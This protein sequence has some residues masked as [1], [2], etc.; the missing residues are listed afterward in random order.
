MKRGLAFHIFFVLYTVGAVIILILGLLPQFLPASQLSATSIHQAPEH[1]DDPVWLFASGIAEAARHDR[2]IGD[3]LIDY[4]FSAI[5]IV[6]GVYL[7]WR[8]PDDRVT[9]LLGVGMIG[10]A[11]AY[12]FHAHT[13]LIILAFLGY[14][15]P[16]PL[17]MASHV[18]HFGLHAISGAVYLHALL[19][20]PDGQLVPRRAVWLLGVIYFLMAQE[21]ILSPITGNGILSGTF[22]SFF[23]PSLFGIPSIAVLVEA[24]PQVNKLDV[25]IE[26]VFYVVLFGLLIPIVGAATQVYRY[27]KVAT[28]EERQQTKIV[29][30]SLA[31]AF[32]VAVLYAVLLVASAILRQ[33]GAISVE[34]GQ[35]IE[36]LIF[37]VFPLIFVIIPISMG[38]AIQRYGLWDI[39]FIVNRTLVYSG[40]TVLLAGIFVGVFFVLQTLMRTL[41]GN[42]QA[43]LAAALSAAV[44]T[45]IFT[46]ARNVLRRYVD[47]RFYGIELDYVQAVKAYENLYRES[48]Q[49]SASTKTS[50]GSYTGLEL[51]GRGGM[52]EVYRGHHP[53]LN[54]RV[55]IKILLDS[56]TPNEEA[57]KRFMREAQTLARLKHPNIV[58]LHDFGVQDDKPYVVME[59]IDGHDLGDILKERGRLP[60][61]EALPILQDIASALDYA[62]EQG[63]VHRDIKPSNVMVEN[64]TGSGSL[65]IHR[66]VLMDFGIAKTYSEQ[67]RLTQ[68]P[69]ILGTLDYISPEQ[70]LG[71]STVDGRADVYSFGV[72]AYQMLTGKLPFEHRDPGAVVMAHLMQPPPDP[73]GVIPDL[74][75]HVA[76]GLLRALTKT[77]EDRFSRAGG[78]IETVRLIA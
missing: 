60:L 64:V 69:G 55:A 45:G 72:M 48:V 13:V 39:D 20:F 37:R 7:V 2:G 30:W 78:F 5:N 26:S 35:Q 47:R 34:V 8:R 68:S 21:L 38:I 19:L 24:L 52:G 43:V 74:P 40:L 23:G 67:T 50:F 54:R 12:N 76:A 58:T 6:V 65:R 9:R 1:R 36:N 75:A 56:T 25:A 44:I 29:V 16:A 53:M 14:S 4:L 33:N 3:I 31:L 70:I 17:L 41:L 49:A 42:E 11:A 66:A 57:R 71:A 73:R 10:T 18:L 61:D 62:H 32:G 22:G 28:V 63:V 46:P 27:R 77:P 15:V 59:Y 51:L